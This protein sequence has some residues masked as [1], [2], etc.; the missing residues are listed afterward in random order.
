MSKTVETK[1]VKDMTPLEFC[2]Y[3]N[4][5]YFPPFAWA[6]DFCRAMADCPWWARWLFR[7]V[8]GKYAYREFIGMQNAFMGVDYNPYWDWAAVG[9]DCS[10]YSD[11]VP[12]KWWDERPFKPKRRL[13]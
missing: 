5:Q 11:P 12:L 6:L 13:E 9:H 8:V 3:M 1:R 7:V 4:K 10:Y 2:Q